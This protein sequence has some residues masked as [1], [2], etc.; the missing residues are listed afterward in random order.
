LAAAADLAK[1]RFLA[2]MS[3]ELRTPL[4]A[5][6]GFA[7]LM[8]AEMF[9]P[10]GADNYR[11]YMKDIQNS[12]QHLLGIIN[13]LLDKSRIELGQFTLAPEDVEVATVVHEAVRIARGASKAE[14]AKINLD[15]IDP[16][17][18]A[19]VD[20]RV[21]RQVLVNLL[22][23][24]AKFTPR[25][26]CIRVSVGAA[27]GGA[28]TLRVVDT[29]A[30]IEPDRMAKIFEPF[31]HQDAGRARKGQGAGLGLWLSRSL[32]ELHGGMLVL[33]SSLGAGTTATVTL[34]PG[35]IVG[36]PGRHADRVWVEERRRA[37]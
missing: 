32:V 31:Q 22:S 24:A 8:I 19:H 13:D 17:W 30:G 34:P 20:R 26:G 28:M 2:H 25:E 37:G 36:G 15:P 29:G 21:I 14:Q 4:N 3:H 35:R 10:L 23:N 9:G 27:A 12:G 33:E 18:I 11:S 16:S 5:I 6:L 7:E 1:S